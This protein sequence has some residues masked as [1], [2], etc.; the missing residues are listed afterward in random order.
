MEERRVQKRVQYED[1]KQK[2]ARENRKKKMP[3]GGARE[4]GKVK[5]K[6]EL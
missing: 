2:K 1:D 6:K 5:R 3:E 4:R